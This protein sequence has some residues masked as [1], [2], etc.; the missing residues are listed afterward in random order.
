MSDP[1]VI[2]DALSLLPGAFSERLRSQGNT[3]DLQTLSILRS[4]IV[5][6]HREDLESWMRIPK[7]YQGK[8][9]GTLEGYDGEKDQAVIALS[10]GSSVFLTGN[11]G[12]GKTHA[13]IGLMWQWLR[14]NLRM[15]QRGDGGWVIWGVTFKVGDIAYVPVFVSVP[16][17]YSELKESFD[18]KGLESERA[19]MDR[20]SSAV[21]LVLDDVGSEQITDW[22]RSV[23]YALID[24]RYREIKQTIITSNLSLDEIAALIDDR[25]ASRIVEMGSVI[26]MTG[27]DYRVSHRQTIAVPVVK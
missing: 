12:A 11:T 23:L 27:L 19:I 22:K 16:E 25:I 10:I 17:L 18:K 14:D 4:E 15:E 7:R 13:A 20:Y 26:T 21:L 24:R 3:L 9:L 6:S 8:G 5:T 2:G 1:V